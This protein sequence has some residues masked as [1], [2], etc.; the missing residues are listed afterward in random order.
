MG[1]KRL[2][3]SAIAKTLLLKPICVYL[4]KQSLPVTKRP[5]ISARTPPCSP[6]ASEA[7]KG[8]AEAQASKLIITNHAA[9]CCL[10]EWESP[11]NKKHIDSDTPP[12]LMKP[13]NQPKTKTPERKRA[14]KDPQRSLNSLNECRCH[15]DKN[16]LLGEPGRKDPRN[17]LS[18]K[19]MVIFVKRISG[20]DQKKIHYL[21]IRR[22]TTIS[23]F[24]RRPPRLVEIRQIV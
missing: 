18:G 13:E 7:V 5:C 24:A 17:G 15:R 10:N 3:A 9:P 2:I 4:S 6:L 14:F 11:E 22:L 20:R 23:G 12:D 16:R 8:S 21:Q 19:E 1:S